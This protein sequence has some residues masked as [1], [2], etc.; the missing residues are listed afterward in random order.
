MTL[1]DLNIKAPSGDARG[2]CPLCEAKASLSIITDAGVSA[3]YCIACGEQGTTVDGWEHSKSLEQGYVTFDNLAVE[4]MDAYENG[5]ERGISTG[6]KDVDDFYTIRGGELT[7]ITGIPGHGKTSWWNQL[8]INMATIH[9]WKFAIYSREQMPYSMMAAGFLEQLRGK[10][11]WKWADHRMNLG[12]MI[13]GQD[14]LQNHFFF[15]EPKRRTL[16]DLLERTFYLVKKSGV[17]GLVL[18][19]WNRI[20]HRRPPHLQETE[21]VAQC[22]DKILTFAKTNH[23]HVWVVIHP[24][25]LPREKDS[26]KTVKPRPYDMMGS[27]HFY[28]M[29]DNIIRVWRDQSAED[30]AVKNEAEITAQ[31]IRFK[32][33]GIAGG[34]TFLDFDRNT[35]LF[36][37]KKGPIGKVPYE[38]YKAKLKMVEVDQPFTDA[39]VLQQGEP[40]PVSE[41][42]EFSQ[43]E[44]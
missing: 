10:P 34:Q 21:Y 23:V 33:T 13:D 18:D 43:E 27:S 3:F 14:F 1:D 4:I 11:F 12:E 24:A 2:D 17:K 16:D 25:K 40:T 8:A 5:L 20:E 35:G 9:D 41:E 22:L 32:L 39:E 19:P 37:P 7:L 28:N 44:K 30:E 38:I 26:N 15:L 36:W 29:A 42:D 6:W 31:K